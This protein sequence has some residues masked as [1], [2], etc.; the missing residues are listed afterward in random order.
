MLSSTSHIS[1]QMKSDEQQWESKN[2]KNDTHFIYNRKL[3]M[4]VTVSVQQNPC[5]IVM[6]AQT[7]LGLILF[8]SNNIV[9]CRVGYTRTYPVLCVS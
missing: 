1:V 8:V 4:L 2:F 6:Q 3:S 9:Y 5:N 7:L